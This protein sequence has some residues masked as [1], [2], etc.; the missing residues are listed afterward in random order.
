VVEREDRD[1]NRCMRRKGREAISVGRGDRKR[2][3]E[4]RR[5]WEEIKRKKKVV[6]GD[7]KIVRGRRE[8][9]GRVRRKL[10]GKKKCK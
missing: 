9:G 10:E 4:S 3:G 6:R 8:E 1:G 7:G 2:V 5:R